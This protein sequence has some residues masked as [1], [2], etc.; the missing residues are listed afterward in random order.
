MHADIESSKVCRWCGDVNVYCKCPYEN[1]LC[2]TCWNVAT[3]CTCPD[4]A[5]KLRR[6]RD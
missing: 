3:E 2:R 4:A 6:L 5:E 1:P